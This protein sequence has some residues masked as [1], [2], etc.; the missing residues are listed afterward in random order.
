QLTRQ[1]RGG[2]GVND[3]AARRR[4]AER[5]RRAAAAKRLICPGRADRVDADRALVDRDGA[6][7]AVGGGE[8][9]TSS[10]VLGDRSARAGNDAGE[11]GV[12][13]FGDRQR[14]IRA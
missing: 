14:V 6:A 4:R 1:R 8:R 10:A 2:P 12:T 5:D 3:G 13:R 9:E 7:E 11:S